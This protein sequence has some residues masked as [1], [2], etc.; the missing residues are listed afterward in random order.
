MLEIKSTIS[1]LLRHFELSV[2]KGY[3]LRLYLEMV[4]KSENG[5]HIHFK[6]R[7]YK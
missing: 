3:E 6:D 1:K 5:V 2:E 7:V 4:L